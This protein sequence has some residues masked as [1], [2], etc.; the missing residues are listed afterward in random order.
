[1]ANLREAYESAA[2]L[3]AQLRKP[4]NSMVQDIVGSIAGD[5]QKDLDPNNMDP[6]GPTSTI[7]NALT[8][9]SL[10]D[11]KTKN[12]KRAAEHQATLGLATWEAKA[13]LRALQQEADINAKI[14][15]GAR[16][17]IAEK[18]AY[19]NNAWE[20]TMNV[21]NIATGDMDKKDISAILKPY[22]LGKSKATFEQFL[23]AI[24][25]GDILTF[26]DQDDKTIGLNLTPGV[27]FNG[28]KLII[29][30]AN[31]E[32]S[33]FHARNQF[34]KNLQQNYENSDPTG[35]L[36]FHKNAGEPRN[37]MMGSKEFYRA[38]QKT[39][40][41]M[42][43]GPVFENHATLNIAYKKEVAELNKNIKENSI[44]LAW[45]MDVLA[46]RIQAYSKTI[47]ET[48]IKNS[49]PTEPHTDTSVLVKEH[50]K[51]VRA[52]RTKKEELNSLLISG[53]LQKKALSKV[54][55]IAAALSMMDN[56]VLKGKEGAA[57]NYIRKAWK[58]LPLDED[59]VRVAEKLKRAYNRQEPN[60]EPPTPPAPTKPPK[61][62]GEKLEQKVA[63]EAKRL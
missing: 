45:D 7:I 58:M 4:E 37:K 16:G 61:G 15:Q 30:G 1:M 49:D 35:S 27:D 54:N 25:A 42:E 50:R 63:G 55:S 41:D 10:Q 52:L 62:S 9:N 47:H 6:L 21:A 14:E 31:E 51:L 40:K 57:Q 38:I 29:K 26:A 39:V 19:I 11:L 32:R 56:T 12:I 46:G 17:R 34:K 60:L 23:E 36:I 24:N 13:P 20:S 43:M 18:E 3:S 53:A 48:N 5:L 22:F 28:K 33:L 59:F 44:N 2:A 8:N